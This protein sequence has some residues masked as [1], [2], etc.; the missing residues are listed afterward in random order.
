[1]NCHHFMDQV[2]EYLDGSLGAA[3]RE[4]AATHVGGCISCQQRVARIRTLRAA[5]RDLPVPEPRPDF[6]PQAL[7]QARQTHHARSSRWPYFAGAALAASLALWLGFGWM[8]ALLQTADGPI[9][10]TITLHEPRAVQLAFNAE[11]EL[12]QATLS[13]QLPDGIE[14]QGFPGQREVRWQTDLARGVN[15]LSLPLVAMSSSGGML[16][17]RLEHGERATEITVP[18]RVSAPGRTSALQ[19]DYS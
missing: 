17:A 18:L 2:E 5:L 14:L 6:F 12:E 11:H 19:Q 16:L 8:P 15:M 13:I 10:V 1:M 4:N 9:G 3:E 7:A